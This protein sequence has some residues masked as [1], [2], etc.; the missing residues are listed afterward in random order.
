[1]R[2]RNTAWKN[3]DLPQAELS[4]RML[5]LTG[6]ARGRGLRL[7]WREGDSMAC[8][9]HTLIERGQ[10]PIP[11][12][13]DLPHLYPDSLPGACRR[14]WGTGGTPCA[15]RDKNGDKN[16]KG[17][18]RIWMCEGRCDWDQ[19]GQVLGDNLSVSEHVSSARQCGQ[20]AFTLR[21]P[22]STS[23]NYDPTISIPVCYGAKCSHHMTDVP[24][25]GR[26]VCPPKIVTQWPK[27]LVVCYNA[28]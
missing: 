13:S 19:I 15:P 12:L 14:G 26:I 21:L 16:Y 28:T 11:D 23:D 17:T 20:G 4:Q 3:T 8:T 22:T 1:M 18:W 7:S 9:I 10:F 2:I 5:R 24:L 27:K 25:S 6:R